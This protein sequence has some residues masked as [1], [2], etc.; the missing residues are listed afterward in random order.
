[1]SVFC[2]ILSFSLLCIL[3]RA[4]VF[5]LVDGSKVEGEVIQDLGESYLIRRK[6]VGN[7]RDEK[8][9]KKAD[10]VQR[11]KSVPDDKLEFERLKPILPTKDL[12]TQ[13]EYKILIAQVDDFLKKHEISKYKRRVKNMKETL[14][15][16]LAQINA[17]SVKFEGKFLTEEER[18][19]NLYEIDSRIE[20]R[21]IKT[22]LRA[23][24]TRPALNAIDTFRDE[25]SH[26]NAYKE[27]H[28]LLTAAY[29]KY[30]GELYQKQEKLIETGGK[31]TS[32]LAKLSISERQNV[33]AQMEEDQKK[34][35]AILADERKRK[36]KYK[37]IDENSGQSL[38]QALRTVKTEYTR[39][40]KQNLEKLKDGSQLYRDS[41]SAIEAGDYEV[42]KKA[43]QVYK[44]IR[45]RKQYY[46]TL[47]E[48]V[49]ALKE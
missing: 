4:E 30:Y 34:L 29:K 44:T 20:V 12:L 41:L 19:A 46:Q 26:S 39:I 3:S 42:A 45:G 22:L 16:E 31:D 5:T 28:K 40:Q 9:I 2:R 18:T 36:V 8:E 43:L 49:N 47:E 38:R 14:T 17:G 32:F 35:D 11:K 13:R 10:I 33:K 21:K 37:T 24:L 27:N 48:Q 6:V 15:E 1:M 7:I 23:G 25:F